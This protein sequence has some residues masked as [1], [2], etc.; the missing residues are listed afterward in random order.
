V[1]RLN[2]RSWTQG[3]LQA[4]FLGYLLFASACQNGSHGQPGEPSAADAG[5]DADQPAIGRD[6]SG[7]DVVGAGTGT[8]AGQPATGR[9]DGGI[10]VVGVGTG[11]DAGQP[12]AGRDG[13]GIEVVGVGTG[14]D[15]DQP[16]IAS[17]GGGIDIGSVTVGAPPNAGEYAAARAALEAD[18]PADATAFLARW[19][20]PPSWT[21]WRK[22]G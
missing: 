18:T 13:S 20:P 17:D 8:D 12:A 9:D 11:T 3:A 19:R 6:D 7:I 16:A 2:P 21:P 1:A 10:D 22:A 15:A 5:A 4:A 14:T